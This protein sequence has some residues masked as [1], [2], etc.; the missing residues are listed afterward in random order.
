MTR[1]FAK[2]AERAGLT[3]VDLCK[4]GKALAK[5]QGDN[6]GGG[7]W[8]K[9]LLDNRLRSIVVVQGPAGWVFTYLFAKADRENI[10]PKELAMFRRLAEKHNG[11]SASQIQH[12]LHERALVEVMCG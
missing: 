5:G 2:A 9:R 1:W 4:A 6:L 11:F 3:R 8:K 10:S 12:A 7:V